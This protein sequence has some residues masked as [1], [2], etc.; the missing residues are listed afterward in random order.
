MMKRFI[1]LF[2]SLMLQWA[3]LQAQCNRPN[4]ADNPCN[5]PTFCNTAQ[6]DAYCSTVPQPI[7]GKV[8]MRPNGFCGTVESPSWF[9]FVAETP[10]LTL[11][12]RTT[13]CGTNGVQVG[14]FAATTCHDSASYTLMSNCSNANGG[15]TNSTITATNLV[16]G[17]T[18]YMLVDGYQSALCNYE[19]DVQAG[20]IRQTAAALPQP[21][22]LFGATTVCG[23]ATNVTYSVPKNVNATDYQ[24]NV[25]ING[26]TVFNGLRA[27]SFYTVAAFPNAGTARVCVTY[28][29]D[30]TSGTARCT[31]IAIAGSTTI[32]LP[33]VYLCP[34]QTYTLPDGRVIDN[35]TPPSTD[36]IQPYTATK[37]GG[38]CDTTYDVQVV[39]YAERTAIQAEFLKPAESKTFCNTTI[40]MPA[41]TCPSLNRVI[42][43]SQ[44]AANGCDSIINLTVFNAKQTINVPSTINLNCAP[45]TIQV[46]LSDTCAGIIHVESFQWFYQA[47]AGDPLSMIGTGASNLSVTRAG[48]YTVVVRDSVWRTGQRFLG[49]RTFSDTFRITVTGNGDNTPL[50]QPALIN[51][52]TDTTIC[53]GAQT[54]LSV[55]LIAGAT[56]YQWTLRRNGGTII[57]G[58]GTN[59]I[60]VNWLPTT[61]GDTVEVVASNA[62]ASSPARRLTVLILNFP[63][64]SAG[65]DRAICGLSTTMQGTNSTNNG[66]WSSALGNPAGVVFGNAT[67]IGS[68]VTVTQTG[69]YNFIWTETINNCTKSDTTAYTFNIPPQVTGIRDSCNVARTN[70]FVRFTISSGTPP[71]RVLIAGTSNS[72]GTVGAG[73]SFLSNPMPLGLNF[74]E[75]RDANNCTTT[76]S[77]I[78]VTQACTTCNTRAG[79]MDNRNILSVCQGDTTR[80]TY[81]GG[82]VD[83]GNDTLQFVLH[84]GNPRNGFIARSNSPRFAFQTGM[85]FNT[86]YFISAVAGDDSTGRV[87][88]TDP[89]LSVGDSVVVIFRQRPTATVAISDSNLCAG[90]C[91]NL[92]F[93]MSAGQAPFTIVSRLT[94]ATTRDTTF[95]QVRSGALVQI[96][97]RQNTTYR[98]FSVRDSFNCVDSSLTQQVSARIFP[99]T[100]AGTS[101][102]PLT[103]CR[104]IDT[105]ISLA[106]R[107]TGA[108]SGGTW[109]EVSTPPSVGGAFTAATGRFRTRNQL[110]GSYRFGYVVR[111][112]AGSPCTNDTAFVVVNIVFAPTADAGR[113]DTIRCNKPIVRI[114]GS[115]TSVGNDI[116]LRWSGGVGGNT[117]TQDVSQPGI[118]VLTAT[119]GA[120][121]IS[122]TVVVLI[123]TASPR[124]IIRPV[125]QIITCRRDSVEL[126]GSGSTPMNE[127]AYLWLFNNQPFDN[128]AIAQARFG[129]TYELA[130]INLRNGCVSSDS[131][132]VNEDKIL[133]TISIVRPAQI[134]CKDTVITIDASGSS[135][136][137]RYTFLW[138]SRNGGR[139]LRDSLTLQ[140]QVRVSGFYK[141]TIT[142]TTNGCLDSSFAFVSIDTMRPVAKA[143][144]T[145]TLDCTNLT[146]GISGRGSTLGA[147]ITYNWVPRSG[148]I[149]SGG[150]TLNPVVD[151]PGI[152]AL[153]VQNVQNFCIGTDSVQVFKNNE[154][155][156]GISLTIRKPVCYGECDAQVRIDRITGGTTPYLYSLDGK[157]FTSRNLF[158][159]QCAG[160]FKLTVQD[161]GGCKI[162]TT[163]SINQDKQLAVSLGIDTTI[164]LGDSLL[165]KALTNADSIKNITWNPL[166][167]STKCPKG[168][169]C[170]EQWVRPIRGTVYSAT[171]TD[172]NGCRVTGQ[173]RVSI[174]K[175]RPVYIPTAFSPNNDNN[176]DYL[177][178]YGSSVVKSIRRF[179]IFDRWGEQVFAQQNFQP[180]NPNFAWDGRHKGRDALPGVYV[181]WIEVEYQ[182][183]TLDILEGDITLIR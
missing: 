121:A 78:S 97:P 38:G 153:T 92:R 19:I 108:T 104:G 62:C 130:V 8:Y 68:T 95:A 30:C 65:A 67:Q 36:Q 72:A 26:A 20:T 100:S 180:D 24:F 52:R 116:S 163:F 93:T 69:I 12:F 177:M 37:M 41:A 113:D 64:L 55:P 117:P 122:D 88:M 5:A 111:P 51:G 140:P 102:P 1:L 98:L 57:S 109:I 119:S 101:L 110:Q 18:Y 84:T 135:T 162:D 107:L 60:T 53:Q 15:Q 87:K 133:P 179:Q 165:L 63:N 34:G 112:V 123:D 86:R 158:Q 99:R 40:T 43:C 25:T 17:T 77:P 132:N 131:I 115:N 81:L 148:N 169:F 48:I 142:D 91:T 149:I 23:N 151:E 181:Y 182:D 136:G 146:V 70:Y 154:R 161:A 4:S 144:A 76:T 114:G 178:I 59:S 73:G 137:G 14:I 9:K 127:I 174:N 66:T 54:V 13:G 105:T 58:Q 27:D 145:D 42:N 29:N 156:Q 172:K 159:N 124:A 82:Y 167:D 44:N 173:I 83:D 147:G 46:N 155:P 3:N 39:L 152:Y 61:S 168:S 6:L 171:V 71:Y 75:V 176:N 170:T 33:T 80:A 134:N 120:C 96:C 106:T 79:N 160:T 7:A 128:N 10:T 175:N 126:N 125:T 16:A 21:S 47:M 94:D 56:N 164:K 49:T 31:D 150:N 74:F 28:V 32:V 183:N 22:A 45:Q 90:S 139:F 118:Y 157:V 11:L 141:L 50:A 103:V 2:A 129:G 85:S 89:C 35:G 166:A 143:V 138:Q